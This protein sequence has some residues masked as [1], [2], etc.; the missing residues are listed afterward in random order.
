[1]PWTKYRKDPFK[2]GPKVSQFAPWIVPDKFRGTAAPSTASEDAGGH[3]DA[4]GAEAFAPAPSKQFET[5]ESGLPQRTFVDPSKP[6][7]DPT[8][9]KGKSGR[10]Q[11]ATGGAKKQGAGGARNLADLVAEDEE[12]ALKLDEEPAPGAL[13]DPLDDMAE[14]MEL[15]KDIETDPGATAEGPVEETPKEETLAEDMPAE[16]MPKEED[17][18]DAKPAPAA[19]LQV[20]NAP[21]VTVADLRTAADEAK[22]AVEAWTAAEDPNS[23]EV[24]APS[25]R[26]L[27]KLGEA[28]TFATEATEEDRQSASELLKTVAADNGRVKALGR[29]ASQWLGLEASKRPSAGVLVAGKVK[30]VEQ[31]GEF[32]VTEV[33]IADDSPAVQVV[34]RADPKDAYQVGSDVLILGAIVQDPTTN[35]EGFEGDAKSVVVQAVSQAAIGNANP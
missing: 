3:T 24:L 21:Q 8:G 23:R 12:P 27:S 30:S 15:M 13:G 9:S 26:A 16:D 14:T 17:V 5:S 7:D 31:K 11:K 6:A 20:Q 33:E 22:T 34:A 18:P 25:Y 19:K 2:L 10:S 1:M 35:L 29:A 28:V 32:S 4:T